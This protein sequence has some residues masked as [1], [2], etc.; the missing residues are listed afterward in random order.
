MKISNIL[1][2][3]SLAFLALTISFASIA[4]KKGRDIYQLKIY[5][6]ETEE[7]I[8][9]TDKY[10]KEAYLPALKRLNISE[11]GV[12]KL[13]PN[14][15]ETLKQIYVLIPFTSL[16]QFKALEGKL[17]KDKAYLAA[18]SEYINASYDNPPYQRIESILMNAFQDMPNM[19]ASKVKGPRKDRVYELRSYESATEAYYVN[20]V[21]MFNAG[22]EIKLFDRLGFNAVFYAEVISGS[23][24]PNLMYMTTFSNQ[25][26]RDKLWKE[27]FSS[28]EWEVLMGEEKY[29]H[30]VSHADKIFLYPTEYSD[31]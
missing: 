3:C 8:A 12:F 4:K 31:Y 25:E 19:E 13:I 2:I 16:D 28:P 6:F 17:A 10:L 24:M 23:K 5:S 21:D 26:V 1:R 27:F 30:N 7:Q 29:K 11:V 20:K 14:D 22:G 9:T 15:S 18:G